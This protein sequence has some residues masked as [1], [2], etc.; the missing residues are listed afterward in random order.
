M[1]VKNFS[2]NDLT[3]DNLPE[4]VRQLRE[5]VSNRE[6]A[7]IGEFAKA[8]ATA[9]QTSTIEVA[10]GK[11][12]LDVNGKIVDVTDS[13]DQIMTEIDKTKGIS[14]TD[15]AKLAEYKNM[16]AEVDAQLTPLFMQDKMMKELVSRGF[17]ATRYAEVA[18]KANEESDKKITV[19]D[20]KIKAYKAIEK[21]VLEP[22]DVVDDNG[23]V[24]RV[25][26]KTKINDEKKAKIYLE[27]LKIDITEIKSLEAAIATMEAEILADPTKESMY[28]GKIDANKSIITQKTADMKGKVES[29]NDLHIAGLDLSKIQ[30]CEDPT[31]VTRDDAENEINNLYNGMDARIVVAYQ[32]LAKNLLD[33]KKAGQYIFDVAEEVEIGKINNPATVAE[34]M[35]AIDD[36][37]AKIQNEISRNV[38]FKKQ[39]EVLKAARIAGTEEYARIAQREQEIKDRF[40]NVQAKNDK[41]QPIYFAPD[42]TETLDAVDAATGN[43][44]RPKQLYKLK[45]SVRKDV[46]T[47]AGIDEDG[48]ID[49]IVDS[50]STAIRGMSW[51]E[52]RAFLKA[53]GIG[54][55]WSRFWR[56]KKLIDANIKRLAEGRG[57][58]DIDAVRN[59]AEAAVNAVETSEIYEYKSIRPLREG[60]ERS[61][62][63]VKTKAAIQREMAN[64][65]YDNAELLGSRDVSKATD[66]IDALDD[67]AYEETS[68]AIAKALLDGRDLTIYTEARKRVKLAEVAREHNKQN[69]D[70]AQN[71]RHED[72]TR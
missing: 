53:Q 7:T 62:E 17:S 45:P 39:E 43:P 55:A 61:Y 66:T 70:H 41:G 19:Y 26:L 8:F 33:D 14:E 40:E 57:K 42:G 9:I 63:E 23:N 67:A 65:A 5:A 1:G 50:N 16:Y 44:N 51:S 38:Q 10:T 27:G 48:E 32:N 47:A 15:S 30:N 68:L 69:D 71:P 31:K 4:L 3:P 24:K 54:N 18:V 13:V 52:R 28:R 56:N 25:D 49:T 20:N 60:I 72:I 36:A 59:K 11:R 22:H 29:L 6:Y 34:G 2:K 12:E 46:L 35:K 37:T 64:G 58:A 21:K